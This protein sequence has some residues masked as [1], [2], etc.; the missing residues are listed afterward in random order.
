MGDA[1]AD[2]S[3]R[4][5]ALQAAAAD[6]E[7]VGCS[8]GQRLDGRLR[9]PRAAGS[10]AR[11]PP[12]AASA[13][14]RRRPRPG[15]RWRP[16]PRAPRPAAW[17]MSAATRIARADSVEPSTA[18]I[19]G[20]RER[21]RPAASAPS[22]PSRARRAGAG[23][24]RSRAGSRTGAGGRASRRRRASPAGGRSRSASSA[25]GG[26]R[27]RSSRRRATAAAAAGRRRRPPSA[28]RGGTTP[29]ARAGGDQPTATDAPVFQ[30]LQRTT[31]AVGGASRATWATASRLSSVP[32]TPQT[33][34]A[35][36]DGE[37]AWA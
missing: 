33:I 20:A 21:A 27:R 24:R 5:Q 25:P 26:P 10:R 28:P 2:A 23:W 9:D 35:K 19:D 34:R 6:H 29:C 17:A 3:E 11:R 15:R 4:S 16:P 7:Q 30:T 8:R 18:T 12:R 13:R 1:F 14:R 36:I 22:A 32:S 31:R 37:P